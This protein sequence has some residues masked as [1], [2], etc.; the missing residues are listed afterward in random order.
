MWHNAIVT[1]HSAQR[2][3][4]P[5]CRGGAGPAVGDVHMANL[6]NDDV[7]MAGAG[8]VRHHCPIPSCSAHESIGHAGWES[9]AASRAHRGPSES[10]A[11]GLAPSQGLNSMSRM[12]SPVDG[13][14]EGCV[15]PAWRRG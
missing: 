5:G 8:V 7:D 12:L 4:A 10:P 15:A 1:W 11:G 13:A 9:W 6:Q 14:M 3:E 2:G